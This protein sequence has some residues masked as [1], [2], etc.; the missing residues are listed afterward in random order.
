MIVGLR[1]AALMAGVA[2]AP[3][4]AAVKPTGVDGKAALERLKTL[5]GEWRGHVV[6]EDGPPAEVVYSVTAGGSTVTE[7]LF[8][9]TAHEMVTMYHL[10]GERS[11]AHPLLRHGQPAAHAP[12]PGDRHRPRWSCDSISRAAPT[13]TPRRTCTCTRAR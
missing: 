9:G 2:A 8:P 6:T 13:S 7:K 12:G 3:A 1:V 4:G 5:A 10:D 11:R